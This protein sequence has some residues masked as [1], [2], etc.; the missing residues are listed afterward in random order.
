MNSREQISKERRR[1]LAGLLARLLCRSLQHDCR[2]P[3]KWRVEVYDPDAIDE[4]RSGSITE[5]RLVKW[6]PRFRLSIHSDDGGS[7][8]GYGAFRPPSMNRRSNDEGLRD[9]L[10]GCLS[11]GATTPVHW[12]WYNQMPEPLR[13]FSRHETLIE[14]EKLRRIEAPKNNAAFRQASGDLVMLAQALDRWY[15]EDQRH[16][17]NLPLHC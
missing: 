1:D 16:H 3:G 5:L 15:S 10:D 17:A 8:I 13:D 14:V 2:L 11:P 6:P 7:L 9:F 4:K 12:A